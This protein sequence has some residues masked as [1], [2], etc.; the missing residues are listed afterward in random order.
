MKPRMQLWGWGVSVRS[1]LYWKSDF[2][3]SLGLPKT[4]H[5]LI[6]V[7]GSCKWYIYFA[8]RHVV[9]HHVL[10]D[11]QALG[12]PYNRTPDLK[13]LKA[14]SRGCKIFR[15]SICIQVPNCALWGHSFY[16]TAVDT[17]AWFSVE[18]TWGLTAGGGG[19]SWILSLS[20]SRA[21]L[22]FHIVGDGTMQCKKWPLLPHIIFY[23]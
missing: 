12:V 6:S 23:F 19:S 21:L 15:R 16:F 5:I 2:W 7:S 3:V 17:K 4:T 13:K 9:C 22:S 18:H 8:N 10:V 20:H 1:G 14:G 11:V